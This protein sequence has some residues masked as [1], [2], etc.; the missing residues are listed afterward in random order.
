MLKLIFQCFNQLTTIIEVTI[1]LLKNGM[2]D[3]YSVK[4]QFNASKVNDFDDPSNSVNSI[5]LSLYMTLPHN[6]IKPKVSY[7]VTWSLIK[8]NRPLQLMLSVLKVKYASYSNL[9]CDEI[10]KAV[11][12]LLDYIYE[13]FSNK[14]EKLCPF[15]SRQVPPVLQ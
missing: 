4:H 6:L 14:G 10:I 15:N 12:F 9:K 3:F 8:K 2:N 7:L 1:N 11:K 13:G 5:D